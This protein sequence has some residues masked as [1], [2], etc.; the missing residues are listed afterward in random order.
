MVLGLCAIICLDIS[1]Y[2]DAV[3]CCMVD[4]LLFVEVVTFGTTRYWNYCKKYLK[5]AKEPDYVHLFF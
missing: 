5:K 4:T 1:G 3:S 2:E